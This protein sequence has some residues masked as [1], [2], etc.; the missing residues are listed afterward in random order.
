MD[1][2]EHRKQEA[3]KR[4]KRNASR[5]GIALLLVMGAIFLASW[6]IQSVA[7]HLVY[8]E[9]QAEHGES[10]V[11]WLQY[12]TLPDFWNRTLQN[13]QSEFLAVGC[14]IAF[15]IYLRQRGSAESKP[16]GSP[17]EESAVASE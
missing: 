8:N 14:M 2:L 17:H 11:S 3:R 4:R 9:E 16:V 6:W 12:L 10:T 7:G 15:S 1:D 5:R 13:W